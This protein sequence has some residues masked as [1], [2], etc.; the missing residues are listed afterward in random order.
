MLAWLE[1]SR[2]L[3][4]LGPGPVESHVAHAQGYAAA[5]GAPAARFLDLGSGGGVPG[6]VLADAWPQSACVLL[7]SSKR[8]TTFLAEAVQALGWEGRV[9]VVRARAEMAGRDPGLRAAFDAVVSRSFGTPAVTAECTA[10]FLRV[11][12]RCIV[13]EPPEDAGKRWPE[14]GLRLL[15]M[16]VERRHTEHAGYVVLRQERVCPDRY[17]RREGVPGKRPLW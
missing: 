5:L 13:S 15:G 2:A 9:Q 3:G 8:R 17:P 10:P 1:R 4:F 11:D 14:S 12:G 16:V 6:L 7:D